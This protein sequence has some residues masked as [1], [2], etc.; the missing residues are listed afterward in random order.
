MADQVCKYKGRTT[1][2]KL[3]FHVCCPSAEFRPYITVNE[4]DV[5]D[6]VELDKMYRVSVSESGVTT[7]TRVD[8]Y[9]LTVT[10]ITELEGYEWV[11]GRNY[12]YLVVIQP[13]SGEPRILQ[14]VRNLEE[15]TQLI[16]AETDFRIYT[17]YELFHMPRFG[18]AIRCT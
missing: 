4:S 2:N 16:G 13:R 14:P 18:A 8:E 7:V 11:V 1:T 9:S 5:P 12:N 15:A 6:P 3:V 10:R 17:E